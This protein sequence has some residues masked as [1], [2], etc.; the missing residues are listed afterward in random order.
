MV[1]GL[2]SSPPRTSVRPTAHVV[3]ILVNLSVM[4]K[5]RS[6]SLF[7]PFIRC[8]LIPLTLHVSQPFEGYS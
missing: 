5:L 3:P 4:L 8:H 7:L 2:S 1:E 6:R